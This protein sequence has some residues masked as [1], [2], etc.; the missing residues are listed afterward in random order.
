MWENQN[1]PWEPCVVV[2]GHFKE[3]A[4]IAWDPDGR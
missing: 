4:D 2:G 1:G 3:V